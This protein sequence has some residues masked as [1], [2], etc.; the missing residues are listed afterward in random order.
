MTDAGRPWWAERRRSKRSTKGL[1]TAEPRGERR[2]MT[3]M[4]VDLVGSTEMA[5]RHEP[6]VV[7]DV[8]VRYQR[9]CGAA[10]DHH[11]GHVAN[12]MG[13]GVLAYFGFPV[14]REHDARQAVLAGMDILAA[15]ERIGAG[16]RADHGVDVGVRVGVHTGLVL[17]SDMGTPD[18]PDRDAIIGAAPNE[19]ARIQAVAPRGAVVISDTTSDI[20]RGYF[21]VE[22]L[23]RPALKGVSRQVEVFRVVGVTEASDRLQAAGRALTPLVGRGPELR[24]LH[25]HWRELQARRSCPTR[26]VLL[27]GEAGIGKS[28]LA[29]EIV[30]DVVAD[31]DPVLLATCSPDRTTSP[32]FPIVRML[33]SHLGFKPDDDSTARLDHLERACDAVGL[34]RPEAVPVLAVILEIPTVERYPPLQLDPRALRERT[35]ETIVAFVQATADRRRTLLVVEDLQ[36]ADQST[37]ELISRLNTTTPAAGLLALTTSRPEQSCPWVGGCCYMI[38]VEPMPAD[39]HRKLICELD[40]IHA[41]PEGSWEVIASRSDGNPLFTEQ[42]ARS[43]S[44]AAAGSAPV[45]FIPTTIRDLLTARLDALGRNKRLAQVAATIGR[46]VDVVLLRTV[47]GLGR[48]AAAVGLSELVRAGILEELARPEGA[49]T[50]RFVHALVRDAA[51]ESQERLHDRRDAHLAVARALLARSDVDAAV[52][53]G[54]FDAAASPDEAVRYYLLAATAAQAGAAHVEAIRLLDRALELVQSLPDGAGRHVDEINIRMLRA[55]CYVNIEGYAS[56]SASEDYRRGLEISERARDNVEALT[57]TAGVWTYY[58][59]R[60]N[61]RAS[62]RVAHQMALRPAP[63][64]DAEVLSAVSLQRFYEGNLV[65]SLA[66]AEAASASFARRPPDALVSPRWQLPNDQAV[67]TDTL[68]GVLLSFMGDSDRATASL[69]RACSRAAALPFPTGPFSQG[70]ALCHAGWLANLDGRFDEGLALQERMVDIAAR[71]G[72]HFWTVPCSFHAA[73]SR[74]QMGEGK[75]A[76]DEVEVNLVRW[77]GMGVEAFLAC[78]ETH[79]AEVRLLVGKGDDALQLVDRVI[80]SAEERGE[81]FF[82]AESHRVRA[83]ILRRRGGVDRDEVRRELETSRTIAAGQGALV[84]ELRALTDLVELEGAGAD[85]DDLRRLLDRLPAASRPLRDVDRA[86]A[87][88]AARAAG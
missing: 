48:R 78:A 50:H 5:E 80:A 39:D 2:Q 84:F 68:I 67:V 12:Y 87:I 79:L 18:R 42:L 70:W 53:A 35:F 38:P 59:V 32:L 61:L 10:V 30:R 81:R 7:R 71:F 47:T 1:V 82:L 77:R 75:T 56:A 76:L 16:A 51:Y 85:S 46:E 55:M 49:I 57:A 22:S 23:G 73:I 26:V 69:K 44:Q 24:R 64:L 34:A 62:A 63:Q 40:H 31:G 41:L 43:I 83:A 74:A 58:I 13:D 37:L 15:I 3:V 20:V 86:R 88:L 6:E 29:G 17:V 14:A 60:G 9:A 66:V 33:E 72:Q 25:E 45:E 27:T 54:H 36:W 52:V 28:R 21:D 4:F 8:V 19:A 11:G 65:E